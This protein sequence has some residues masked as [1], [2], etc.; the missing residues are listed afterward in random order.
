MQKSTLS[1]IG[2]KVVL[3]IRERMCETPEEML[4]SEKFR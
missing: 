3:D 2:N 4:A 1:I